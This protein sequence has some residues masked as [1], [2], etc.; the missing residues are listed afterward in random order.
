MIWGYQYHALLPFTGCE[1]SYG[2]EVKTSGGAI[3]INEAGRYLRVLQK[4]TVISTY[5]DEGYYYS[6]FSIRLPGNCLGPDVT[7]FLR[8]RTAGHRITAVLP[9][10]SPSKNKTYIDTWEN[11]SVYDYVIVANAG[12]SPPSSYGLAVYDSTG[13]VSF[14]SA[15]ELFAITSVLYIPYSS[16]SPSS[17]NDYSVSTMPYSGTS[18]FSLLSYETVI[19]DVTPTVMCGYFWALSFLSASTCRV[20]CDRS[21]N[22]TKPPYSPPYPTGSTAILIFGIPT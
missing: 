2:F 18:Y 10:Y 15:D 19:L 13:Q 7:V 22:V 6:S 12:W 11:G 1:M 21:S 20:H 5:S 3:Q 17:S 4:G 9:W 8:N 14:N 16:S